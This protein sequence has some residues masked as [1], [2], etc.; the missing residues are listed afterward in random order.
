MDKILVDGPKAPIGFLSSLWKGVEFVNARPAVLVLPVLLDALLW[1]G[2]HLSIAALLSP[3]IDSL[4]AAVAADQVNAAVIDGLRQSAESF[5]L[6]SMLAFLPV[7]PPSLM[8]GT[9]PDQ[10]PIGNPVVLTVGGWFE[11]AALGV[12]FLAISLMIGSLYWIL[13]GGTARHGPLRVR[14]FVIRWARTCLTVVI[15]CIAFAVLVAA[16]AVPAFIA[17]SIVTVALPEAG[18]LLSN[19]LFF[20][21]G[22]FLFWLVLFFMFSMHGT[23]LFNDDLLPAVW[24]SVNTSRWLYP[25]SIW[26]PIMLMLVN[27]LAYSVWSLAPDDGWA[28]AVG[29]LGNAY[30]GSVVV[31]ASMAYY[32]DKRR[33]I[34]EVQTYLQSR[35]AGKNPPGVA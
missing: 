15:L 25:L 28:G 1:F 35:M 11:A 4:A 34:S 14:D 3:L 6:F 19:L 18:V 27:Y 31:V 24:N 9:A 12:V 10:T 17:I 22:G 5:N 23:A 13:A 26:I 33:W 20:L 16:F 7:F 8:A 21:G 2:P 29:V 32:I 30:T